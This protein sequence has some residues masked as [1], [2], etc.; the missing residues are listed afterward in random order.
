MK[1]LEQMGQEQFPLFFT[2]T[3]LFGRRVDDLRDLLEALGTHLP[4]HS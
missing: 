1:G 4:V 2:V 3:R